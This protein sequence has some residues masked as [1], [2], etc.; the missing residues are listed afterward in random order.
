MP[1]E[2][3][4]VSGQVTMFVNSFDCG[5]VILTTIIAVGICTVLTVCCNSWQCRRFINMHQRD[6][7]VLIYLHV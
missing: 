7:G 2:A 5:S 4:A 6:K 1:P 3:Y